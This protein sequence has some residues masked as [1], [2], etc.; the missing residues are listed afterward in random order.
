MLMIYQERYMAIKISL[1]GKQYLFIYIFLDQAMS[2]SLS[3]H[4]FPLFNWF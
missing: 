1:V 3:S 4:F 2:L